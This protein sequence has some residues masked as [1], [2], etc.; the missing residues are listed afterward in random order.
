M[1]S[2]RILY[3]IPNFN[4]AGSGKALLNLALGLDKCEFEVC[5]ACKT[6]EG[7]LFEDV[8]NSGIPVYLLNFDPQMRPITT[9]VREAYRISK[10]LRKISPDI[11]HS[12]HYNNN[13]SEALA[14]RMAGVSWIFTK[15]N[16]NWGGDGAN[17]WKI[18]S[19]LARRIVIQNQSMS[20]QFF[21]NNN[22]TILIERGIPIQ[23]YIADIPKPKIREELKTPQNARIII[24]V[25]NLVPIKGVKYLIE[26]FIQ[27]SNHFTDWHL[28]LIGEDDTP[29]AS[30]LYAAISQTNLS[31]RIHFSGKR[32]D[33]RAFLN[34]AEIFV[35]PTKRVGEG[36]PVALLE[37]M[38]NGK[39]VLGSRVSG[40]A[41]ILHRWPENLFEAENVS[42][43]IDKLIPYLKN[44]TIDNMNKGL[45]FLAHVKDNYS[46]TKEIERH[47]MLYK[48]MM[49]NS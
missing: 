11:I 10:K 36:S 23:R 14:A 4:T 43:I 29:Y 9:L 28:W 45:E 3:T 41:S 21:P 35:L 34:H 25:A 31:H 16:M 8:K 39:V 38:A 20:E 18:R 48:E 2:I 27:L 30:E 13:Y 47:E 42:S 6:D 46:L 49:A 15:K 26:A 37:A 33:V 17:A 12:F 5:I 40:I 19:Y 24:C 7:L 1:S 44:S 22:K 32:K